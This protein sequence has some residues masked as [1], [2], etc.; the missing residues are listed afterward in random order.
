MSFLS[1]QFNCRL[2]Y[3]ED[4]NIINNPEVMI[5]EMLYALINAMSQHEVRH[6][7]LFMHVDY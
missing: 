1:C 5:T 6:E 7:T 4:M 2:T 3:K